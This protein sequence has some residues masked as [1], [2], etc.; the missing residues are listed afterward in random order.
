MAILVVD[1]AAIMRIVLKDVLVKHCGY[2]PKDIVEANGGEHA[3]YQ[4][5]VCKPE[6]VLLDIEMP[7]KTGQEVVVELLKMDAEAKIIMVTASR[8][9]SDVVECI[10]KGA[11]DYIVKPPDP[12]RIQEAITKLTGRKFEEPEENEPAENGHKEE[13]GKK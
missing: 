8:D 10:R 11:K 12:K 5:K 7:D 1:D 6:L 2:E 9:K 13:D 3:I 4:Y